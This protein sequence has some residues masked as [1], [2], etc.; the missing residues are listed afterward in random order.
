MVSSGESK[1]E[2]DKTTRTFGRWWQTHTERWWQQQKADEQTYDLEGEQ[3]QTVRLVKKRRRRKRTA[4]DPEVLCDRARLTNDDSVVE[5]MN[6]AN[7]IAALTRDV[8]EIKLQIWGAGFSGKHHEN[9]PRPS[10]ESKA[11]DVLEWRRDYREWLVEGDDGGVSLD[12]LERDWMNVVVDS[13]EEPSLYLLAATPGILSTDHEDITGRIKKRGCFPRCCT[14]FGLCRTDTTLIAALVCLLTFLTIFL[15]LAMLANL[16]KRNLDWSDFTVG[17]VSEGNDFKRKRH[18]AY[19]KVLSAALLF[20][21]LYTS[22]GVLE[23]VKVFRFFLLGALPAQV[24]KAHERAS[25]AA[26]AMTPMEEG[27]EL[28]HNEKRK[29]Q[30]AR[31]C[32][33]ALKRRMQSQKDLWRDLIFLGD[34]LKRPLLILG[35]I[36]KVTSLIAMFQLTYLTFRTGFTSTDMIFNSLAL[37]FIL[38]TDRGLTSALRSTLSMR[39]YVARAVTQLRA[40]A[41]LIVETPGLVRRIATPATYSFAELVRRSLTSKYARELATKY[42]RFLSWLAFEESVGKSSD[43]LIGD[44][45]EDP[46]QWQRDMEFRRC[47]RS[48]VGH[49]LLAKFIFVYGTTICILQIAGNLVCSQTVLCNSLSNKR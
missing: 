21:L 31:G 24:A 37:Q 7:R 23:E 6:E 20:Y 38:D 34:N 11:A 43:S 22:L 5:A 2:D 46:L 1:A 49:R 17:G 18:R 15:P 26:A 30:Q 45:V 40:E 33:R 25:M 19:L 8:E 16:Y 4:L 41:E 3:L 28:A 42:P 27:V 44:A 48:E 14:Y 29:G 36:S 12:V 9:P 47:C 10:S 39:R 13:V 35:M 32:G